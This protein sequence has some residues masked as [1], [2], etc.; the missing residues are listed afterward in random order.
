MTFYDTATRHYAD[1]TRHIDTSVLRARLLAHVPPGGHILDAGCG[2]GR[3]ARAFSDMGHRVT[4]F[5]ASREMA[6]LAQEHTGLPVRVAEFMALDGPSSLGL[7]PDTRFDA[8]W[9]CASLCSTWQGRTSL[10]HG[11]VCGR[12]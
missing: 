4:A 9:A 8:I 5:D 1:A 3:D 2:S 10:T 12:C 11:R 6:A 7:P